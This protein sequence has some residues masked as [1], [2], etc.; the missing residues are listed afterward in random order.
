[1]ILHATSSAGRRSQTS[2]KLVA[3]HPQSDTRHHVWSFVAR[4]E[5]SQQQVVVGYDVTVMFTLPE[6]LSEV[7]NRRAHNAD[8]GLGALGNSTP[9]LA[10]AEQR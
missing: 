3:G 9:F 2:P 8:A 5:C 4:L 1:M 10:A 7:A 6:V